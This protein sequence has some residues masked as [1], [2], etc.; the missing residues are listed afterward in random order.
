MFLCDNCDVFVATSCIPGTHLLLL[1]CAVWGLTDCAC[2]CVCVCAC[3]CCRW[4]SE[5]VEGGWLCEL[6]S[7]HIIVVLSLSITAL[8]NPPL[9]MLLL[10]GHS[11]TLFCRV[12]GFAT[13]ELKG[14]PTLNWCHPTLPLLRIALC[15]WHLLWQ[16]SMC[17]PHTWPNTLHS[18]VHSFLVISIKAVTALLKAVVYS[19]CSLILWTFF[20]VL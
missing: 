2:V 3:V 16:L 9:F 20:S 10:H 19:L 17:T 5:G 14:R 1:V 11:E 8:L 6:M 12:I 15:V 7:V 18:T 4:V 13:T